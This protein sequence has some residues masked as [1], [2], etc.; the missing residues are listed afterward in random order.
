MFD[1][2]KK[3]FLTISKSRADLFEALLMP[4]LLISI[5]GFALGNVLFGDSS[6]DT[7]SVGLIVEQESE[8]ELEALEEELQAEGIPEEAIDQIKQAAEEVDPGTLFTDLIEDEEMSDLIQVERMST[9][10]AEQA[11]EDDQIAGYFTIPEDFRS[12]VWHALFLE[13][14]M[15]TQLGLRIQEEGQVR[16]SVLESV[17]HSFVEQ[18]NLE[19]SIALALD[20]EEVDGSEYDLGEEIFLANEEPVNAFQYYTIG[21]GAMY[22]LSLASIMSSRAFLEKKQHVFGRIMLSGTKPLTYLASKML[23]TTLICIAQLAILFLLS[24]LIFG[25]FSGRNMDFWINMGYVTVLFSLFVGSVTSLLTALVLY[26]S[27]D[28]ASGMFGILVSVLAFFGGSFTPIE[29]FGEG[30]RQVAS[31]VPN[32]TALIS[33]L[34]LLQGFEWSE[35]MPLMM[36]VVVITVGCLLGA[37]LIFPKRRLD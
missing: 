14:E 5:L 13:E 36:R 27:S 22:A 12:A 30:F 31:W 4:I 3:D 37:V 29:Q 19:S 32:G 9:E 15:T 8:Q 6:I 16:A 34:Q 18:F 28:Q 26:T 21:M 10:E 2:I 33:Y 35:I 25:T 11:L 24:T 23:S 1:L 17:A 20:G 7:I